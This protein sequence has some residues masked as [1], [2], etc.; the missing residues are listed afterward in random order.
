LRFKRK[1]PRR[2]LR[3][4]IINVAQKTKNAKIGL[5]KLQKSKYS[6]PNI[7]KI[8]KNHKKQGKNDK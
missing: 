8:Q 5:K 3:S 7:V 6:L 1:N 4:Q 2:K